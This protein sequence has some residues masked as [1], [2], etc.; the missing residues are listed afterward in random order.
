M[1][2]GK[3]R[4]NPPL[5]A[6]E[7]AGIESDQFQLLRV[8]LLKER[9]LCRAAKLQNNPSLISSDAM[10]LPAFS[11]RYTEEEEGFVDKT[12]ESTISDKSTLP[13]EEVP[14]YGIEPVHTLPYLDLPSVSSFL[15]HDMIGTFDKD[16]R[17]TTDHSSYKFPLPQFI[18][19]TTDLVMNHSGME[20][21]QLGEYLYYFNVLKTFEYM[22]EYSTPSDAPYFPVLPH[23]VEALEHL[24]GSLE[25][26]SIVQPQ[27]QL[28]LGEE[29]EEFPIDSLAEFAVLKKLT[30]S[31]NI[32]LGRP[33]QAETRDGQP[34]TSFVYD[35]AYI[36]DFPDLNH[37]WRSS[38]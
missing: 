5:L 28:Y 9:V 31:A 3:P 10:A 1:A 27:D 23:V 35:E 34:L 14:L 19:K 36:S 16:N 6:A 37:L 21:C 11:I 22:I 30:A 7:S 4:A 17:R 18:F 25:Q 29:D 32:L 15:V 38:Q 8:L 20:G 24:C 33:D 2:S 26:L 13:L 12:K